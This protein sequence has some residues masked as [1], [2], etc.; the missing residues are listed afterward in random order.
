MFLAKGWKYKTCSRN[1]D[2]ELRNKKKFIENIHCC[3]NCKK[4]FSNKRT[5]KYKFC[6]LQCSQ[7]FNTLDRFGNGLDNRLE[8]KCKDCKKILPNNKEYFYLEQG[9]KTRAN[10]KK[11]CVQENFINRKKREN[12]GIYF[13]RT[14]EYKRKIINRKLKKAKELGISYDS[15]CLILKLKKKISS[16]RKL[17]NMLKIR[18][19]KC[20]L[21]KDSNHYRLFYKVTN[22]DWINYTKDSP[23]DNT[24]IYRIKYNYDTKFN[25][26]ERMR[27]QLTKKRK[28]Y[29]NLDYAIR[30]AAAKNKNT[31]YFDILGYTSK[32]LINHLQKQFTIGMTWRAFRNGDIHIDH[33]KPQSLFDLSNDSG[34]K[35]CW[36]LD[37]LQPL[38]AADNLAKSNFYVEDL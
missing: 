30:Q 12:N 35:K 14:N 34:Y 6:S 29:P 26:N 17:L 15:W 20:K 5:N 23:L 8:K 31:K 24:L 36:S 22:K 33:I 21:K 18:L 38:W 25:L 13:D 2:Y 3:D 10:C 19:N 37:N 16:K 11:C 32:K 1:C 28:K 9:K 27:T 7:G 4:I